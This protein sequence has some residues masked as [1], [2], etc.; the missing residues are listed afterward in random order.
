L[1]I[2]DED[3][4]V[5]QNPKPAMLMYAWKLNP[6]VMKHVLACAPWLRVPGAVG[7]REN[8]LANHCSA[9]DA[10]YVDSYIHGPE[11]PLVRKPPAGFLEV[12]HFAI[13]VQ[14]ESTYS[15]DHWMAGLG[16]VSS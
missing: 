13:G 12:Q 2:R 6:E 14:A 10:V 1:T 3:P 5:E 4:H 11:G 9:C 16:Q 15:Q 7:S 8:Y